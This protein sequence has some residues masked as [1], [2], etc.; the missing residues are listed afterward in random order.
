M[1]SMGTNAVF[2]G[3]IVCRC[4]IGT[5]VLSNQIMPSG[6]EM[7]VNVMLQGTT[8]CGGRRGGAGIPDGVLRYHSQS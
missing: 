2:M 6:L 3:I 4:C 5:M 8:F 7:N 1:V